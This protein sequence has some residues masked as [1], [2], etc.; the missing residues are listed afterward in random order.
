MKL[1]KYK[2]AAT[3]FDLNYL[4]IPVN[5]IA[6]SEDGAKEFNAIYDWCKANILNKIKRTKSGGIESGYK[7]LVPSFDIRTTKTCVELTL[8]T[9]RCYRFQFRSPLD[10]P[11]KQEAQGIAGHQAFKAFVKILKKYDIDLEEYAVED[12]ASVKATIEKPHVCLANDF[13]ADKT[14]MR[15]H[16]IDFH[17]SYPAGLANTHP[18]FRECLLDL[19]EKRKEDPTIKAIFNYSIGFMQSISGCNAKYAILSRDAIKDNNRRVEWLAN[20]LTEAGRFILAYNTDGIWYRGDIYHGELEGDGL[21]EWSNDHVNCMWRAKSAGAYEFVENNEYFP[22][23]RGKTKLDRIKP[24][25]MWEWGDI[26]HKDAV[27]LKYCY[28]EGKG[29][30]TDNG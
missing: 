22:V 30:V 26:Y 14:F 17:S 19:Y 20:K 1:D 9:T 11:E 18:E 3:T 27:V 15:V 5:V 7:L 16:H 23:V 2:S 12:G 10:A 21:G 25:V 13:I 28:I 6:M 8:I 4:L 29:I 24:R